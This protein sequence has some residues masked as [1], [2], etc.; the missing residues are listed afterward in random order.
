MLMIEMKLSD[1]DEWTEVDNTEMGLMATREYGAWTQIRFGCIG[2]MFASVVKLA[3][4]SAPVELAT[5]GP[6]E[7]YEMTIDP[8]RGPGDRYHVRWTLVESKKM[9]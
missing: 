3:P 5:F 7:S 9:R 4:S 6:G 2:A 8:G 1:R